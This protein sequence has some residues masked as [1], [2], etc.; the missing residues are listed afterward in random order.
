MKR[1]VLEVASR[2]TL[3]RCHSTATSLEGCNIT[4]PNSMHQE[5]SN[6][7]LLRDKPYFQ[8]VADQILSTL[9]RGTLNSNQDLQATAMV[10]R[11][12]AKNGPPNCASQF[13]Q[14]A[15]ELLRT[16][17]ENTLRILLPSFLMACKSQRYYNPLLMSHAGK[18]VMDNLK[19]FNQNE[20]GAI[21]HAYAKL[22]HPLPRLI[23]EVESLVLAKHPSNVSS[24]LLWN[25]AWSGMVFSD[26]PKDV[27]TRILTDEY[28]E[29]R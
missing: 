4:G 28:I 12:I 9:C 5:I 3:V 25:L 1:T 27:L 20:L 22:N 7:R 15:E 10:V 6:G 13:D 14:I 8:V 19:H 11:A 29:G 16:C 24:H 23:P 17:D 18:F 21:V 2:W 26:Y